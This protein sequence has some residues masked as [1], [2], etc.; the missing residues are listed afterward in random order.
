MNIEFGS[1]GE[2]L[3]PECGRH[4]LHHDRV[5]VYDRHDGHEDAPTTI[6]TKVEG[7]TVTQSIRPSDKAGNPSS[8]R[9]GVALRFWCEMCPA[10]A[11]L[12]IE[13]HKGSSY[14][15]WRVVG[16]R[17]TCSEIDKT[18]IAAEPRTVAI[19]N[20]CARDKGLGQ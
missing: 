4:C 13:Q 20:P 19:A 11:E 15:N 18:L 17:L 3:C 2:L 14:L 12:T 8:R 6:I 10:I 1:C 9:D 7:G 16:R 5:T